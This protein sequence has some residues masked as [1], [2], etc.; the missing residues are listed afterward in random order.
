[1][2]LK[3]IFNG[4]HRGF[5]RYAAVATI[6][7]FLYIAFLSKDSLLRLVG[8]LREESA[9][10]AEIEYYN[11]LNEA[12]D[13]KVKRLSTERDT[14]EEFARENFLFAAPGEDI[15]LTPEN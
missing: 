14:L 6:L 11:K 10:N 7:A 15:F 8:V 4:Q 3:A 12:L 9:T 2:N 13:L 5:F 1:M